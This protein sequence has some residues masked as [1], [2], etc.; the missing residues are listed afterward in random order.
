MENTQATPVPR[1]PS[2]GEITPVAHHKTPDDKVAIGGRTYFQTT[3]DVSNR[4][5]ERDRQRRGAAAE[6]H[7]SLDDQASQPIRNVVPNKRQP[8]QR[9]E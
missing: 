6:S 8:D 1:G 9:R 7:P 2:I 3:S 5:A 4:R